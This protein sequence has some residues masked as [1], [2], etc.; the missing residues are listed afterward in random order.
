MF[1]KIKTKEYNELSSR[2]DALERK[3]KVLELDL[4]LYVRKLKASKGLTKEKEKEE[5][6]ENILKK[7]ILPT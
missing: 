1:W 3:S 2:I 6:T 4:E 7:V 5:E